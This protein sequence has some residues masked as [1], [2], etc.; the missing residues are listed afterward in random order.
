MHRDITE[1]ET[2]NN[3]GTY[4]E[5]MYEFPDDTSTTMV[6]DCVNKNLDYTNKKYLDN[7]NDI[8]VDVEGKYTKDI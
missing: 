6:E 4:K 2:E 1:N 3:L 5:V 8:G 7:I